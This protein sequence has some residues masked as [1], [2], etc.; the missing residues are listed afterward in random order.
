MSSNLNHVAIIMDGNGRWAKKKLRPVSFGHSKGVKVMNESLTWAHELGVKHITFYAF[1]TENWRRDKDE[2]DHLMKLI[3]K[4]YKENFNEAKENN[5]RFKFIGSRVNLP[6]DLIDIFDKMEDE[7]KD[8]DGLYANFAF[9][10]GSRLEIV[11]AVNKGISE[12]VTTFDEET[13]NSYL[14]TSGQ[15]DVDL[16]IRTSG[17]QRISNFLLW[18]IAYSELV[19]LDVLWPDFSYVAFKEAIDIYNKRNR[20]FGGR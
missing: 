4:Y 6:Q 18:Q 12:G 9:N 3:H 15:P 19:F 8:K 20:R 5:V 1:S 14:Y 2:V 11:E 7:T 13:L 17:E 10:Y 16:L